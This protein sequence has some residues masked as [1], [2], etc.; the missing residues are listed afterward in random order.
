MPTST[1]TVEIRIFA[2]NDDG[3]PIE[4]TVNHE[5]EFGRGYLSAD[6]LPWVSSGSAEVDGQKLFEWLLADPLTSHAWA[7]I[8]G[9]YPQRRLLLRLDAAAPEL[10]AIPWELLQE[11]A[12]DSPAKFLAA[13]ES[14]P[15]S[16]YL[17]GAMQPG[18]PILQRPLKMLAVVANPDNLADY[19]LNPIDVEAEIALLQASVAEAEVELTVL[20]S[21]TLTALEA[22]LKNGYHLLHGVAHGLHNKRSGQSALLLAN[23][24]NKVDLVTSQQ[25]AE[26]LARQLADCDSQQ[27]DKLR[28]VFLAA[29]QSATI[30]EQ[31]LSGLAQA[32]VQAGVPAVMAMQDV[33]TVETARTFSQR[34]YEQLL[35]HGQVDLASNEARSALLTGQQVGAAIPVL[36][37]RLRDGQL[38]ELA[39]PEAITNPPSTGSRVNIGEVGGDISGNIAGRDIIIHQHFAEP[40]LTEV[41]SRPHLPF[42]PETV[43][44]PAGPF[45]LGDDTDPLAAPR[46]QV[47]LPDY[48]M[49]KYP[50]TVAQYAE[51]LKQTP[52][53]P[54]PKSGWFLRQPD[55]SLAPKLDHPVVQVSEAD[56]LAYCAWL[57]EQSGCSYR[58]PTEAEWEKAARGTDERHYPWGNEWQ[59]DCCNAEGEETTPVDAFAAGV[60]PYGCYDM[61][62]NVREWT[63]TE[64]DDDPNRRVQRGG[65]YQDEVIKLSCVARSPANADSKIKR[66][67]FRIV[68]N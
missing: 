52:E 13:L 54:E 39:Q 65:A 37:M 43:L 62:G 21:A 30:S 44:I 49:G 1:A 68:K 25:L 41:Q 51:F 55:E 36:F 42:E 19:K 12:S 53:Q 16:R 31:A 3:Y 47:E 9:R 27:E 60:S 67:G 15:F 8:R 10:H 56:A 11:T 5:Q 29:C 17:A 32:L 46:H 6:A 50:V 59:A 40:A 66:R 18:R 33:V 61:V 26:M 14:T 23:A 4:L 35:Q 22:E 24:E 2:S 20:E 45:W 34:F 48:F 58:L 7:E 38:F 63:A 57:S 64:W 28:L